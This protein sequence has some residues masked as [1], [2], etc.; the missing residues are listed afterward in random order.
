MSEIHTCTRLDQA[1]PGGRSAQSWWIPRHSKGV[2][3]TRRRVQE[4]LR[5]WGEPADRVETAALVV[6]ELVTN[7]VQHAAGRRIRCRVLRISGRVRIC[8]WNRGRGR[9]AVPSRPAEPGAGPRGPRAPQPRRPEPSHPAG[10]GHHRPHRP[11]AADRNAP[12]DLAPDGPDVPDGT[13]AVDA[14][15]SVDPPDGVGGLGSLGC[16][17]GFEGLDGFDLA[18]LAEGGRGLMLVDAL[19][20]RWGTRTG[21]SGRLVWADI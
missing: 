20:V 19:A 15:H 7:A 17:D 3:E 11:G 14:S 13:D 16:P 21:L 18:S 9:V 5:A 8:V 2:P 10:E 4:A 12:S 1:D 6:T